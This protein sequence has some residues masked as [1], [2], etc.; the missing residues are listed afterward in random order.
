MLQ[1]VIKNFILFFYRPDPIKN[2]TEDNISEQEIQ[3]ALERSDVQQQVRASIVSLPPD[4]FI[5][6]IK[7]SRKRSWIGSKLPL[8]YLVHIK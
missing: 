8:S 4:L 1:F 7:I 3:D 5:P 6:Q 2:K